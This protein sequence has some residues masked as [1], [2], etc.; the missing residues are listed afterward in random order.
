MPTHGTVIKSSPVVAGSYLTIATVGGNVS[1]DIMQ[2][3]KTKMEQTIDKLESNDQTELASITRED[4]LGDLFYTGVLGYFAQFN[5]LSHISNLQS[6]SYSGLL[7]SFGTY[8]YEPQVSYFFGLPHAVEMGGVLMDL[9]SISFTTASSNGDKKK[10]FNNAFRMGLLS[11][12][13]EHSITEQMFSTNEKAIDAISAVKA[14]QKAHTTGQPIFHVTNANKAVTLPNIHLDQLTMTEI[15]QA[16]LAG[17][18]VIV[19][20][21]PI[22]SSGWNGAG[23]IIFDTET[24]SGAFK[25]S[26]GSNGGSWQWVKPEPF[27]IVAQ[28]MV[29]LGAAIIGTLLAAGGAAIAAPVMI[30]VIAGL[31]LFANLLALYIYIDGPTNICY[32][33]GAASVAAFLMSKL[34]LFIPAAILALVGDLSGWIS[35]LAFLPCI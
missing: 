12:A 25:I 29:V 2:R 4:I 3:L 13:L 18:E 31:I 10:N 5:A 7:P 14:L 27:H 9:D 16:L 23:Y 28:I 33:I 1:M 11:S 24:G 20:P 30:G 6:Q 22:S 21:N 19:H 26:G 34:A 15:N 8:G 32:G 35:A 17:H